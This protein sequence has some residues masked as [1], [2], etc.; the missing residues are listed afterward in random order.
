MHSPSK[1]YSQGKPP[2]SVIPAAFFLCSGDMASRFRQWKVLAQISGEAGNKEYAS[3]SKNSSNTENLTPI[4]R[5]TS[6]KN[7]KGLIFLEKPAVSKSPG[8]AYSSGFDGGPD[9]GLA[10]KLYKFFSQEIFCFGISQSGTVSHC[11]SA[12]ASSSLW[13]PLF[14]IPFF[15][16][17][18]FLEPVIWGFFR[19][20]KL[21]PQRDVLFH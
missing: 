20:P 7:E 18:I 6:S 21:F 17:P 11:A 1:S 16:F 8:S 5:R 9:F 19:L 12:L 3:C 13:F 14:L 15:Q 10:I 4:G 2:E